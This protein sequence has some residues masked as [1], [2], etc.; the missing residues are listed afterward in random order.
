MPR[1]SLFAWCF[2]GAM[3]PN[4]L[5]AAAPE[6]GF[7][8]EGVIASGLEPGASVAWFSV[9]REPGEYVSR[10]V[11]RE[12]ITVDDDGDGV[13][14]F[15]VEG[16]AP[17]TSVWFAVDLADGAMAVASPTGTPFR[18]RPL[19]PSVLRQDAPGLVRGLR[20]RRPYVMAFLARPGAG[21]WT[22]L[23]GDGGDDDFDGAQDGS[24]EGFFASM[25]PVAGSA[26]APDQLS[27]GDVLVLVD[28]D[29]MQFVAAR[30]AR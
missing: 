12:S 3:L 15:D 8:D 11:R 22:L 14:R 23:L 18:E 16:P 1:I 17:P 28:P 26:G 6:I 5:A 25:Q 19:D 4:S 30:F 9:A 10:I 2:V 7:D 24:V 27:A 29:A 21:A 13:A 20:E